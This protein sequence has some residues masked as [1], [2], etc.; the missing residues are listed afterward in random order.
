[1][2]RRGAGGVV[3][4]PDGKYDLAC[5]ACGKIR[6]RVWTGLQG[7]ELAVRGM[8]LTCYRASRKGLPEGVVLD[9]DRTYQWPCWKCGVPRRRAWCGWA[10]HEITCN[11]VCMACHR[12]G[13]ESP[14]P[15]PLAVELMVAGGYQV[16]GLRAERLLALEE[17]LRRH[18]D[19][20]YW[21]YAAHLNVS[22]RTVERYVAELRSLPAA[23]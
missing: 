10:K 12:R 21:R 23:A 1:M 15:D 9:A 18:P 5:R 2:T 13:Y 19:W 14:E 8:C 7:H 11:S 4:D 16:R 3:V 17:L 22:L 6:R 20:H